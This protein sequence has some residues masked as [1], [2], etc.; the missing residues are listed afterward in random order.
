LPFLRQKADIRI[1]P[2]VLATGRNL[3]GL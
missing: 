2:G 1:L 3:T